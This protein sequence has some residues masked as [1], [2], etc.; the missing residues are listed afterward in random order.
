MTYLEEFRATHPDYQLTDADLPIF[1]CPDVRPPTC[2][3]IT[4]L[5]CWQRE[6]QPNQP[7]TEEA[8]K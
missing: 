8:R 6:I 3:N 7:I 2:L 5:A 4:C 1:R